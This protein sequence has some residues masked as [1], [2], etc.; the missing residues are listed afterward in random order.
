MGEISVPA[1]TAM[2]IEEKDDQQAFPIN[3]SN[4]LNNNDYKFLDTANVDFRAASSEDLQASSLNETKS[5]LEENNIIT[6]ISASP[7]LVTEREDKRNKRSRRRQSKGTKVNQ[8]NSLLTMLQS[9][10]FITKGSMIGKLLDKVKNYVSDKQDT[11]SSVVISNGHVQETELDKSQKRHINYEDFKATSASLKS[12]LNENNSGNSISSTAFGEESNAINAKKDDHTDLQST[13]SIYLPPSNEIQLRRTE[14]KKAFIFLKDRKETSMTLCKN[15]TNLSNYFN[16]IGI[17]GNSNS[18]D[19]LI[20]ALKVN[21]FKEKT[22]ENMLM[23]VFERK[24]KPVSSFL[25]DPIFFNI[26]Q[27]NVINYLRLLELSVPK[28]ISSFHFEE[29][30][31]LKDGLP[32]KKSLIDG[33]LNP[34]NNVNYTIYNICSTV[35]EEENNHR[36]KD[37]NTLFDEYSNFL[38]ITDTISRCID[39]FVL[40]IL[41]ESYLELLNI[42][43]RSDLKFQNSLEQVLRSYLFYNG[44]YKLEDSTGNHIL[45]A[46]KETDSKKLL[47]RMPSEEK[48]RNSVLQDDVIDA[49]TGHEGR[50]ILKNI[51]PDDEEVASN[52]T[53]SEK[54]N[55]YFDEFEGQTQNRKDKQDIV[56]IANVLLQKVDNVKTETYIMSYL[57]EE[58]DFSEDEISTEELSADDIN[59]L[60]IRVLQNQDTI[61]NLKFDSEVTFNDDSDSTLSTNEIVEDVLSSR[62]ALTSDEISSGI[63]DDTSLTDATNDSSKVFKINSLESKPVTRLDDKISASSEY[64]TR[65][66]DSQENSTSEALDVES[67][68]K[69]ETNK[70]KLIRSL[71]GKIALRKKLLQE[72]KLQEMCVTN[73]SAIDNDSSD[74]STEVSSSRREHDSGIYEYEDENEND[75]KTPNDRKAQLMTALLKKLK[76]SHEDLTEINV[77]SMIKET[78]KQP[79]ATSEKVPHIFFLFVDILA[80]KTYPVARFSNL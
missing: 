19:R 57:N 59:K 15:N 77:T 34:V 79:V 26:K 63:L 43:G 27:E 29:S 48:W 70:E 68:Q 76:S 39:D 80:N 55:D 20:L 58:M 31:T 53:A 8:N 74:I 52:A 51:S 4:D 65:A 11:G 61:E 21:S 10:N 40:T 37:N 62:T 69:Q 28:V 32:A 12:Y 75:M 30:C 73:T 23:R 14:P 46:S 44:S 71:V 7:N 25:V 33:S 16:I 54:D 42:K 9:E 22:V 66:I 2:H 35:K 1:T 24:R 50:T 41:K 18:S 36:M 5:I 17:S 49:K 38:G 13:P 45:T 6:E 78:G 56:K 72:G 64:W 60:K 47:K 3:K 67:F